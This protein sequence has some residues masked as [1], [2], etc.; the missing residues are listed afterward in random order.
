MSQ[1]AI[2][3]EYYEH[4]DTPFIIEKESNLFWNPIFWVCLMMAG[5]AY[6]QLRFEIGGM[7]FHP[8]MFTLGLLVFRALPRLTHFPA[9]IGRPAA[10][11]FLLYTLS[12][13]QGTGFVVQL[14][15]ISVMAFTFILIALSVRTREDF[16]AGAYG[17][18]ACAGA[19]CV[20]GFIRGVEEFGSINPIEGSQKNAFSLY[21]LP[22][23]TLCL[24]L[25]SA[26]IVRL[27]RKIILATIVTFIFAGIVL[28]K[29][30]SGWLASGALVAML[31]AMNRGRVKMMIFFGVAAGIAMII[32]SIVLSEAENLQIRD[33]T[34]A[35]R[36]DQ[37]RIQLV[38]R[39]I[40]IGLQNPVLGVS[41]TRLTRM[42][43]SIVTVSEEGVD[44]HNLT[45]YLIGGCGLFTFGAFCLF[46]FSML[47]PPRQARR[48]NDRLIRDS[49]RVLS[50]IVCVWI[51]RAQFQEDVIFSP[52][53]TGALGLCVGFCICSGVYDPIPGASRIDY[54]PEEMQEEEEHL[55][56]P[57]EQSFGG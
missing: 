13:I 56:H 43:G 55:T 20:K 41:P 48:V 15:K 50:L 10:L 28:S 32:A 30:R 46:V 44:C 2:P 37:L 6:K 54:V 5:S 3:G 9:R 22:A 36:S 26:G 35:E 33:A 27:N 29:N 40:T 21:Y 49:I 24:F 31:M 18:G 47:V 8:Y 16:I 1:I 14:V 51:L 39:A 4:D 53:F 11:F 25:L 12:L 57:V 34:N 19:L 17:L 45:G 23:L 38:V 7:A 52:T 42:L